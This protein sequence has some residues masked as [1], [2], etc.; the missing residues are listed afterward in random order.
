MLLVSPWG[1]PGAREGLD[2][3]SGRCNTPAQGRRSD[4][5]ATSDEGDWVGRKDF[6][7]SQRD[8]ILDG[9]LHRITLRRRLARFA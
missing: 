3:V 2:Q 7:L 1:L 4:P 9:N 5:I 8:E 6:L